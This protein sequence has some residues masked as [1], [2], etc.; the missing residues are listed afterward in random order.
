M[1]AVLVMENSGWG[2]VGKYGLESNY[3]ISTPDSPELRPAPDPVPR[4]VLILSLIFG[5]SCVC[6]IFKSLAIRYPSVLGDEYYYSILSRYFGRRPELTVHDKYLVN[7][8]N[9]LYLW[10]FSA[11]HLFQ[12]NSYP[13]AKI[14]NSIAF[15][16]AIFP[17]YGTSRLFLRR[18]P[19]LLISSLIMLAPIDSYTNYFMPESCYFLGFWL[20]VFLFLSNL[21]SRAPRAGLIGGC[22]LGALALIKPHALVVL[23][24]ANLTILVVMLLPEAALDHRRKD[25]VISLVALNVA[26]LLTAAVLHAGFFGH[27]DADIF[28]SYR[29]VAGTP[30]PNHL[31][32][33]KRMLIIA[34]GHLAYAAPIFGLPILI[35]MLGTLGLL[36][37]GMDR[38]RGQLRIF[39]IFSILALGCLLGITVSSSA[40]FSL[41]NPIELFRIHTRYYNFALPLVLISFYALLDQTSPERCRLVLLFGTLSCLVLA[42]LGWRFFAPRLSVFVADDP[43]MAWLTQPYPL[44]GSIFW[45]VTF[46]VLGYYLVIGIENTGVYS[47]YLAISLIGGSTLIFFAQHKV[48]MQTPADRGAVLVSNLFE[49][50]DGDRGVVIGSDLGIIF[51]CLF[52]IPANPSVL[53]LRPG[54]LVDRAQIGADKRWILALDEYDLRVPST[55]VFSAPGLKILELMPPRH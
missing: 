38:A 12:D 18:L 16:A 10:L 41:I 42:L 20:F 5:V 15:A 19:A 37:S 22:I 33:V 47:R 3:P 51:R 34:T 24:A 13:F 53:L 44:A 17:I 48:D 52:G 30:I 6:L 32:Y 54:A 35:T 28:G 11:V 55:T 7:C 14:F 29:K 9:E 21:P 4:A 50:G 2:G 1:D 49:G 23:M 36:S 46:L 31:I 45:I 8:P 27:H 25:Y 39:N 40:L 26:F 43:E